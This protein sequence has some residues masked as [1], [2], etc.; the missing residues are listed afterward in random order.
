MIS[1]SKELV[2]LITAQTEIMFHNLETAIKTCNLNFVLCDL[3]L[4]KHVY[5]TLHSCDQWFV[6]PDKY[7]EPDFHEP[8][9][10]SL[11]TL[12][13]KVL[14]KNDLLDY[15]NLVKSKVFKYLSQLDDELLNQPPLGC[16]HSRLTL[17]LGQFRHLNCH[18]GNINCTTI[19]ETGRWPKVVGLSDDL[20]E[21]LYEY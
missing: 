16:K 14:C 10:N 13:E 6:N 2:K 17:I 1:L 21:E 9:L 8:N 18:L 11:N 4:W 12:S 5:H 7:E 3:Q 15:F 19:I 20:S